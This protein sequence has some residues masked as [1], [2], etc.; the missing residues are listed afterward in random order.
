MLG[1]VCPACALIHRMESSNA[2]LL[3]LRFR[4]LRGSCR[5]GA[6]FTGTAWCVLWLLCHNHIGWYRQVLQDGYH[7]GFDGERM[8]QACILSI[9][10]S[11]VSVAD[12]D[13]VGYGIAGRHL[14]CQANICVQVVR[15]VLDA[16]V[17]SVFVIEVL[18]FV[19][20]FRR[21]RETIEQ[22]LHEI[23]IPIRR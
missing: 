7:G 11:L 23:L 16:C 9:V 10:P 21:C 14:L 22:V 17:L 18:F 15:D 5:L 13:G 12:R 20:R 6:G 8:Q 1:A 19:A 3:P 4:F 2:Q